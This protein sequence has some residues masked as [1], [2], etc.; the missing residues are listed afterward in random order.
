MAEKTVIDEMLEKAR[1]AQ[2][3]IENYTQE[4]VDALVKIIGRT[5]YD[6]AEILAA[7][8]V[9][10]THFGR[11][12]SK[13]YKQKKAAA[14]AWFYLRDKKSVG[15]IENDTM[16]K[17]VT[18]AKPVGVVACL[19]PSTN[20][21]S[22]VASNGMN[23]IKCRN[24]T[25]VSPHP[26]AKNV[27]IHGVRLINEALREA[28]APDNLIQ[29]IEEP[30]M[31]KTKELMQKS[32]VI[33]ATGGHAM[34]KSAYSSGRPSFGVG[35]GNVQVI[36]ADDYKDYDKAA[37]TIVGGRAYDNGIPCT[38]E[39]ALHFPKE[40]YDRVVEAFT[41][42]KAAMIPDDRAEGLAG[43]LFK[44][45]GAI[46][47]KYVGM[48]PAKLA[49]ELGFEVPG[50]SEVLIFNSR[51]LGRTNLLCRE[52]LCPV[53]QLFPYESFEEGVEAAKSNLLWEG[54]GHT[55]VIYTEDEKKAEYAGG[56]LPVG[57]LLVNQAGGAASGGNYIN[58]LEP[59]MSLGCGS[60]GNNSISENLTYRH[61][62]NVTKLAYY[63]DCTMPPLDE[64][65][66]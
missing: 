33:V 4:Q 26:G 21:T 27:T 38:G 52:K 66:L 50:D 2:A 23:I 9:E 51:G 32:D 34:V 60:W 56:K 40:D 6:H 47:P 5:I 15:I 17:V 19:A 1:A 61:L 63:H 24:S 37:L 16:N 43:L 58:G 10:E 8:A 28:G 3:E 65:W 54:A 48:K 20:P 41:K 59:T 29:V 45:D 39:Q 46:N 7:E 13:I 44:E 22:T 62:M 36:I 11:V 64:V 14:A 31:D 35:Q 30:G 25:I 53:I 55:S 42:A 57:R 49:K 12:D 18:F